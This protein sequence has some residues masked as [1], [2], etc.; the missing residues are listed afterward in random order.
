MKL[1]LKNVAPLIN[2]MLRGLSLVAR[3]GLTTYMAKFLDLS[4]VGRLGLILGLTGMAPSLLG[5]GANY[6]LGREIVDLTPQA[7]APP[8]RDRLILR[9][10][11]VLAAFAAYALISIFWPHRELPHLYMISLIILLDTLASDIHICLICLGRPLLAN[12]L[13]FVRSSAWCLV[14]IAIG[15]LFPAWRSLD[16]ILHFW[17]LSL[18]CYALAIIL[19]GKRWHIGTALRVTINWRRIRGRLVEGKIIYLNEICLILTLYADRY[20][21]NMFTDIRSTGIFVLYW[22]ISNGIY[23]LVNSG[24]IEPSIPV[25]VKA[26]K[27]GGENPLEWKKAFNRQR[28]AVFL[29]SIALCT[30]AFVVTYP[31]FSYFKIGDIKNNSGIFVLFLLGT[32]IRLFS[33]YYNFGLYAQNRDKTLATIN[34]SSVAVTTIMNLVFLSLFGLIGSGIACIA[35][36][37]IIL[38]MRAF[39]LHRASSAPHDDLGPFTGNGTALTTAD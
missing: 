11:T 23:V 9:V 30:A 10:L 24:L 15:L 4:D 37:A 19:L 28:G 20:F 14:A 33:D 8:I 31:I 34:I 13:F 39:A 25:L 3:F 26:S 27:S 32:T 22:S 1:S 16:H 6:F 29:S 21:V 36:P 18:M 2:M 12:G 17:A 38:A 5:W 35:T 7:A